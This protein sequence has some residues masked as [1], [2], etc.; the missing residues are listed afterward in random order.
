MSWRLKSHLYQWRNAPGLGWILSEETANLNRLLARVSLPPGPI[1]DIGSGTGSSLTLFP[2]DRTVI[3]LER[4]TAMLEQLPKGETRAPV[5]GEAE[6]LPIKEESFP[7]VTA[8][9]ITEYLPSL[10]YFFREVHRILRPGGFFLVTSSPP[11]FWT[12]LRRGLGLPLQG[13]TTGAIT[14]ALCRGGFSLLARDGSF[15]QDQFLAGKA[16]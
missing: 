11:G 2:A 1:L 5:R 12:V 7:L 8:I 4:S 13:R 15:M 16:G 9:G 10:S 14:D 3:C 6:N